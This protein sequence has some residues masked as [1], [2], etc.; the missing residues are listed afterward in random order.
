MMSANVLLATLSILPYDRTAE[1]G[2]DE[3]DKEKERIQRM[4]NILGFPVVRRRPGYIAGHSRV[5]RSSMLDGLCTPVRP[6]R[7]IASLD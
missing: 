4:A 1:A 7:R 3:G 6:P 5:H 2:G